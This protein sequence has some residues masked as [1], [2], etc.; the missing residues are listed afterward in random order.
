[1]A[2]WA[3]PSGFGAL[4]NLAVLKRL[5]HAEAWLGHWGDRWFAERHIGTALQARLRLV[6][7][8]RPTIQ[9]PGSSGTIWRLHAQ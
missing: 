2:R 6:L 4:S 5:P 8:D 9:E 7:T 3:E 1:M